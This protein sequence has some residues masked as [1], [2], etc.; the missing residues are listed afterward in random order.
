MELKRTVC[1]LVNQLRKALSI[2]DIFY[3][4]VWCEELPEE[5]ETDTIYI[6]GDNKHIWYA[7][8]QCPCGCGEI[9]DLNLIQNQHPCWKIK[10][11]LLGS[12]TIAP[13]IWRTKNCMSH[14]FLINGKI[15]WCNK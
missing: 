5:I 14:F 1:L 10:W 6:S 11:N 9:I 8:M 15:H 12:I 7:A 2:P 4:L 13:S 3:R